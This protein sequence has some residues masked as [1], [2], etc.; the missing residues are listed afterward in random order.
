MLPAVEFCQPTD[1]FACLCHLARS[2][3]QGSLLPL[4]AP[5]DPVEIHLGGGGRFEEPDM[6]NGVPTI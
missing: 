3:P 6:H 5:K 1:Q 4:E 2:Q